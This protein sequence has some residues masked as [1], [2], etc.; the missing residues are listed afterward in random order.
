LNLTIDGSIAVKK[1]IKVVIC[2]ITT[3]ESLLPTEKKQGE[4]RLQ[5]QNRAGSQVLLLKPKRIDCF[6]LMTSTEMF[7]AQS[8]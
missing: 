5:Q 6:A 3:A 1:T 8:S 7:C 2:Q 4:S